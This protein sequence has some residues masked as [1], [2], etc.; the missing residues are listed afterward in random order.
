MTYTPQWSTRTAPRPATF[1]HAWFDLAP[2]PGSLR[3]I[4]GLTQ[5][6]MAEA[7]GYQRTPSD[8]VCSVA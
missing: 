7:L 4:L 8:E 3:A 5:A 1:G 2:H 6:E